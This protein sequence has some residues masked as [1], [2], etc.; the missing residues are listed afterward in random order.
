MSNLIDITMSDDTRRVYTIDIG[1]T[2]EDLSDDEKKKLYTS[3]VYLKN[4]TN[5]INSELAKKLD[6]VT[7][8]LIL[9]LRK[10]SP[11]IVIEYPTDEE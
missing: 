8:E 9:L 4:K 2:W 10:L 7:E 11:G 3:E 6:S 5:L 1:V